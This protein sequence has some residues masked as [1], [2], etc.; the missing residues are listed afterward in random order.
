MSLQKISEDLVSSFNALNLDTIKKTVA[1][2]IREVV[3]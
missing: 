3:N 2:E 1:G